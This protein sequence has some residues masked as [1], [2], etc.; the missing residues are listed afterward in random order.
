MDDRTIH[1]LS[2]VKSS[3]H[4]KNIILFIDRKTKIPSEIANNFNM[5][6]TH[7][8]KNLNSLRNEGLVT[9]LNENDKR[10]RLYQLTDDGLNILEI[11]KENDRD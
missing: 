9:C 8:S 4:R 6:Y 2:F 7:T 11:L 3:K 5:S 1:L 10:G